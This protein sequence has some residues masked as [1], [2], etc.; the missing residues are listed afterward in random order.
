SALFGATVGGGL[1]IALAARVRTPE[2]LILFG[3]ALSS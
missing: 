2:A 1:L 3:V